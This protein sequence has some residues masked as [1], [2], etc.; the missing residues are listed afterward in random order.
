MNT[1]ELKESLTQI[2]DCFYQERNEEGMDAFFKVTAELG[3]IR[4]IGEFINPLF[5][6][7]EG[8]DYILAADILQH[9]MVKRL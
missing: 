1:G 2:A 3:K 6:A 5:D 8:A 7:L 9:E 4:G